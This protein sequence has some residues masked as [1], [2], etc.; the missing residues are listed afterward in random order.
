MNQIDAVRAMQ[1]YIETHIYEKITLMDL[2]RVSFY[3][4]WYSHRL[5]VTH[6][7]LTPSDYIRKFK[8]SQSALEL[9]DNEAKIIDIAYRYGYD[10]VDGYQRAFHKEFGTNPYEYSRNP[11]PISLFTPFKI[12]EKK[13][14][15]PMKK[16]SHVFITVI[17]KPKRKVIIKRG[18]SAKEYFS[19]CEEVG[20][21]VWGVLLSMKSI[22]EEPVSLWLP[23]HLIKKDTSEYVQGVEVE[24]DYE[25]E[26]PDGFD[27]IDLPEA[28]YLMFQGEPFLEEDYEMA[29]QDLWEAMDKYEPSALGYRYDSSNPRIQL[30]PVGNRGYIELKPVVKI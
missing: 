5:F 15:K 13:E 23:K 3:S 26:I 20:C 17:T 21:D 10:S 7:G 30:A 28:M 1:N 19:Y 12:Y 8:L 6:L 16:T 29:I 22:S 27:I 14:K 11:R 18:T 4:P 2:S 25:G 9:R 24:A